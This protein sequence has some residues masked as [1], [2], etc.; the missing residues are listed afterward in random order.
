MWLWSW[1]RS[2]RSRPSRRRLS[3]RPRATAPAS[4]ETGTSGTRTLVPTNG[5]TFSARSARPRCSSDWPSP[6]S[7]EHTS[8]LQSPCNLVCRLL[9]EK[10]NN[11]SRHVAHDAGDSS[12]PHFARDLLVRLNSAFLREREFHVNQ[13][14]QRTVMIACHSI[15]RLD[16]M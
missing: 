15:H 11:A 10:K 13:I 9:L 3:S 1:N 12:S 8:E 16:I 2:T 14:H 5:D 6:R 7:E 4:A